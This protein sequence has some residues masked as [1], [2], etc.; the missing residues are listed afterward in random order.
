MLLVLSLATIVAAIVALFFAIA[1]VMRIYRRYRE[2]RIV[3]CPETNAPAAVEVNA[4]H[5]AFS[6]EYA[7]ELHMKECSRWPGRENCGEECLRQI[8]AAPDD[9][10]IRSSV[11]RWYDDKKCALCGKAIGKIDWPVRKPGVLGPDRKKATWA[12]F[13]PEMLPEIMA[14]HQPVCWNC[15]TGR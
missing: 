9:C 5:Y 15:T 8:E 12:E 4:A 3:T 7:K 1:P 14:T 11:T 2:T 6:D 13:R 10:T